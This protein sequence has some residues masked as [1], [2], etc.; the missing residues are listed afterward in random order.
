VGERAWE[1]VYRL[2]EVPTQGKVG[3]IMREVVYLFT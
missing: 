1:I 2:V 3:E